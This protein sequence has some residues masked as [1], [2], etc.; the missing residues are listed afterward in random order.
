MTIDFSDIC[1]YILSYTFKYF[2]LQFI[3]KFA[4]QKQ[5]FA[6]EWINVIALWSKNK[7]FRITH[8]EKAIPRKGMKLA[9]NSR[10]VEYAN[11]SNP[12]TTPSFNILGI[13]LSTSCPLE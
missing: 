2:D 10:S 8:H 1:F 5:M 3:Y 12:R 9:L 13:K 7:C 4:L 6:L 11:K